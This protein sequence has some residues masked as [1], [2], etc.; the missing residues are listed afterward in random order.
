M[1][2]EE[3]SLYLDDLSLY[4]GYQELGLTLAGAPDGST[5]L[6]QFD[7]K[8]WRLLKETC[9]AGYEPGRPP[10]EPGVFRGEIR[11]TLGVLRS[12]TKSGHA[13]AGEMV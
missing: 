11:R 12:T 10:K 8:D 4:R 9:A 13:N 7:G 6:W 2:Q 3:C 5:C 1:R